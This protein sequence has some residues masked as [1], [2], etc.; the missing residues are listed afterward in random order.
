M[1]TSQLAEFA[2]GLRYEDLPNDVKES[3]RICIQDTVGVMVFGADLP[4]SRIVLDS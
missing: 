3:A 2:A 1:Q 4:W